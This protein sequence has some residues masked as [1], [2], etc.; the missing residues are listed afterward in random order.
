[1]GGHPVAVAPDVDD[2]TVVQQ[3]VNQRGPPSP[4]RRAP[5]PVIKALVGGRHRRSP[6]VTRV[7]QLKEENGAVLAHRQVADLRP[8]PIAPHVT[9]STAA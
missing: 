5:A 9:G 8:S 3:A 7:N 4:R 2:V 6:F 1:M